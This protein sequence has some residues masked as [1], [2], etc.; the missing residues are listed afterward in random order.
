MK[1]ELVVDFRDLRFVSVECGKCHSEI[2]LDAGSSSADDFPVECPCC[3]E[4][5]GMHMKNRLK[6]F[7]DAYRV[8]TD[9]SSPHVK[10]RIRPE[11]NPSA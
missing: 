11:D 1:K 9:P 6:Q 8:L 4:S 7:K 3:H 10:V 2:T 5:I